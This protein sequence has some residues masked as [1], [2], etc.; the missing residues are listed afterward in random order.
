[1][2]RTE[3][4]IAL[5]DVEVACKEAADGHAWTAG[6]VADPQLADLLRA[7]ADERRSFADALGERLVELG[8]LPREPDSDLETVRDLVARIKA[9]LSPDEASALLEDRAAAEAHLEACA[10]TALARDDLSDETR[11]LLQQILERARAA[12]Q[13]MR[14]TTPS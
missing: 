7:L 3:L 12:K 10:E 14:T 6:F 5:N 11:A 4:Q 9:A 8:D 13:R 2:L 1:M